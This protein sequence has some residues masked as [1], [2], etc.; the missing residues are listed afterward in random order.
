MLAVSSR[1]YLHEVG[2][3]VEG[4]GSKKERVR[5]EKRERMTLSV[6]IAGVS[7]YSDS[8]VNREDWPDTPII[9]ERKADI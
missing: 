5:N 6:K 2:K 3:G 9:R 8:D 4:S 1:A 7:I